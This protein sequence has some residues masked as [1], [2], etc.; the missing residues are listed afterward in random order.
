MGGKGN[1]F[2]WGQRKQVSLVEKKQID[3]IWFREGVPVCVFE[4]E[5]TTKFGSGFPRLY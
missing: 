2:S 3:V 4:V 1:L 5:H